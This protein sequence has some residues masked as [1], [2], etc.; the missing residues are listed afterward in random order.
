MRSSRKF[1]A[2]NP[3]LLLRDGMALFLSI[4]EEDEIATRQLLRE[5]E[6]SYPAGYGKHVTL[7]TVLLLSAEQKEW[8]REMY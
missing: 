1:V 8:L 5:Y 4:S 2:Q 7:K 6:T 3:R